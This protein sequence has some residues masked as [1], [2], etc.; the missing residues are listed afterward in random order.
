MTPP[1]L[2]DV[3]LP[4]L[5]GNL[6]LDEALLLDAESD[7]PEVVRFWHWPD[8]AVVLGAGG[9]LAQDV[10]ESACTR[11]GVP[12]ARRSSGGGTVLLGHGCLLFSLILKFDRAAELRDVHA[13]YRWIL[14]QL[15][16]C[17][18]NLADA[19]VHRAGISD[20]AI[21]GRKFSGNAQHRK[22]RCLLHHGT[23]L[24]DF[25]LE[26]INRYLHMPENRPEYRG[27]R[28]HRAF[29]RNLS[30]Q[31]GIARETI[32]STL[33]SLWSADDQGGWSHLDGVVRE[34][35][36]QKYGQDEWVRRR[37]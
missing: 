14:D 30:A 35:V 8:D 34:L 26:R 31:R 19:P 32:Q 15:A 12:I 4:T 1:Y 13:S 37:L 3:T 20:L 27:D 2:I 24:F 16:A 33:A 10:N 17:L 9:R 21:D 7:G 25:D 28:D 18:T 6:A 36:E 22:Q 11:D 23:I 5:A 29:V